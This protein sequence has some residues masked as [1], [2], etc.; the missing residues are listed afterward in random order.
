MKKVTTNACARER[1]P[2][3]TYSEELLSNI[4]DRVALGESLVA[5]C[6]GDDMP[7]RKAFFDWVGKDASIKNRYEVAIAMRADVLAEDILSIADDGERDSYID[8]DGVT[9]TNQ[10]VIARSRLRVDARKWLAGKMAPKKYGEKLELAGDPKAPLMINEVRR[11][12]IDPK[13]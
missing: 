2:R 10:E 5:V 6:N 3:I 8:E 9:R 4:L 12:I 13:M 11:L 7:S 1:K